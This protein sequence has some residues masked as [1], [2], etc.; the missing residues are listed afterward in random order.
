M[1]TKLK[2]C[3]S[4]NRLV[5]KGNHLF[6][7]M[8][9]IKLFTDSKYPKTRGS[10]SNNLHVTVRF[11]MNRYCIFPFN[12]LDI[13]RPIPCLTPPHTNPAPLLTAK[14]KS[15]KGLGSVAGPWDCCQAGK[16]LYTPPNDIQ[17]TTG[18]TIKHADMQTK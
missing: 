13:R 9:Q 6:C 18:E 15:F 14:P 16:F 1:V 12:T 7:L 4:I 2:L 8:L 5:E 11:Q 3:R 10:F 17:R